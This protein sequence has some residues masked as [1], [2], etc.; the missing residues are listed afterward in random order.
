MSGLNFENISTV[1]NFDDLLPRIV[2]ENVS[3]VL[4]YDD[5]ITSIVVENI[6]TVLNFELYEHSTEW[7]FFKALLDFL[8]FSEGAIDDIFMG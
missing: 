4:N 1:L 6:S 8:G 2:A 7:I 3:T 5:L